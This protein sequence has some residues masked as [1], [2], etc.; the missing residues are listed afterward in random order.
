MKE[1]TDTGAEIVG[2]ARREAEIYRGDNPRPLG[3]YLAVMGI[4]VTVVAV[5]TALAACW[6]VPTSS[7]SPTRRRSSRPR[8]EPEPGRPRASLAGR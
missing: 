1:A 7:S 6:P 2:D 4:Y 3:G 8:A 5:A